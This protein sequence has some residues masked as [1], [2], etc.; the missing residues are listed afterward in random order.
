MKIGWKSENAGRIVFAAN[1]PPFEEEVSDSL[2]RVWNPSK[3]LQAWAQYLSVWATLDSWFPSWLAKS[4][5]GCFSG[6]GGVVDA[7]AKAN[8]R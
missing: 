8:V 6:I 5:K 2:K 4:A 3:R 7:K 1:L